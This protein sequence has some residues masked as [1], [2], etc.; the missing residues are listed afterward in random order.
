MPVFTI[1][2]YKITDILEKTLFATNFSSPIKLKQDV[3][4][5]L[6]HDL[7]FVSDLSLNFFVK[8][9]LTLGI[10]LENTGIEILI[11]KNYK[12]KSFKITQ[13]NQPLDTDLFSFLEQNLGIKFKEKKLISKIFDIS[14]EIFKSR[15]DVVKFLNNCKPNVVAQAFNSDTKN[16][17]DLLSSVTED[18]KDKLKKDAESLADIEDRQIKIEK[19]IDLYQNGKKIIETKNKEKQTLQNELDVLRQKFLSVE[20]FEKRRAE[21]EQSIKRI[22]VVGSVEKVA[23]LKKER[24]N[25]IIGFLKNIKSR[26]PTAGPKFDWEDEIDKSFRSINVQIAVF[27]ILLIIQIIFG[28]LT[29]ILSRDVKSW[30]FSLAIF[31]SL[32]ILLII[33]NLLG[34]KTSKRVLLNSFDAGSQAKIPQVSFLTQEDKIF[35]NNAYLNAY[36]SE[37]ETINKS[38]QKALGTDGSFID[39]KAMVQSTEG[40][41]VQLENEISKINHDMYTTDEYYKKRRELDILKI[42][43]ENLEF[44]WGKEDQPY[45]S[46]LKSAFK[47]TNVGLTLSEQGTRVWE[48]YPVVITGWLRL[49]DGS[50]QILN[51][52]ITELKN[53]AQILQLDVAI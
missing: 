35:V 29:L 9:Y 43:K 5:I 45:L 33:Y 41:L 19:G 26:E 18:K 51:D 16:I 22:E 40:K 24:L 53:K 49:S 6:Q 17:D 4:S 10:D 12:E 21:L 39:L 32:I 7:L 48:G 31:L 13:N 34:P 1:K 20:H 36:R 50:L 37:L 25:K 23:I 38:M 52:S 30:F 47:E 44:S 3:F 8:T 11:A 28:I 14:H 46:R 15:E 27:G 42:E 2:N